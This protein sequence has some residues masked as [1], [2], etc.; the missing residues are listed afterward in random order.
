MQQHTYSFV[1]YSLEKL[2]R[3]GQ[4]IKASILEATMAREYPNCV[5]CII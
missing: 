2:N 4:G 5:I 1:N 3:A